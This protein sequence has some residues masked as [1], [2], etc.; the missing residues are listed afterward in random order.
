MRRAWL[1][2]SLSVAAGCDGSPSTPAA[3][4][5]QVPEGTN[6]VATVGVEAIGAAAV[7][8]RMRL[9]GVGAEEALQALIE[10]ELL[11]Q[12]A[13]RR[14]LD[15]DPEAERA[16]DRML[17]RALL[18]DLEEENDP[19]DVPADEVRRDFEDNR[20]AYQVLER[21]DSKHVLVKEDSD[22]ARAVIAR[23]LEEAKNAEDPDA[24][25]ERYRDPVGLGIELPLVVEDLPPISRKGGIEK[26]Y[27]DA[28]FALEAPGLVR[29]PVQTTYGWH[30]IL[31]T[32]I[33]PGQTK[34]LRDVEDDI[35]ERLSRKR[36]FEKLVEIVQT[37][38]SEG[39][40]RYEQETVERLLSAAEVPSRAE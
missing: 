1:C 29:R 26:G 5:A 2:V 24:V 37:L 10:E 39:L 36:R 4:D 34:T 8:E 18:H 27:K 23:V 6:V 14:N 7:R 15:R 28:I 19:E 22:E 30:A 11:W 31:V 38:E 20:E 9:D 17:V 21:R 13:R 32:E 35:R 16:V 3:D 40:V 25:F 12:G 33:L